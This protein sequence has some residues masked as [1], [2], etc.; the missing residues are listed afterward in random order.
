MG[1]EEKKSIIIKKSKTVKKEPE[2]K[3]KTMDKDITGMSLSNPNPF[4]ERLEERDPKLFVINYKDG[5]YNAYS[6]QCQSNAR[7]QPVILTDSEKEYI[8]KEHPGSYTHA[9]K[10]GSNPDKQYWYIC[11][12]YWS[13]IKNTSLTEEEVK[14][15]K[16]GNVIP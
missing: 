12:R 15:G 8:D 2:Y 6:R 14:S 16:Y 5:K 7:R 3:S 11:P 4:S 13:L 9:I 1:N 10:Y